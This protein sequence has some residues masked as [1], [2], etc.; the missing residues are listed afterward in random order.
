MRPG[1]GVFFAIIA[2][3]SFCSASVHLR[4]LTA[5][6]AASYDA[7]QV[8]SAASGRLDTERAPST[9]APAAS[10]RV[11]NVKKR[12]HIREL[13]NASASIFS[14]SEGSRQAKRPD[15]FG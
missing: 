4:A 15:L 6:I 10:R 11:P 8:S 3:R 12:L 7:Y 13:R 1:F 2:A 9:S 5:A 14:Q